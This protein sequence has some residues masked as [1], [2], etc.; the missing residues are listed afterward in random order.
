MRFS[1]PTPGAQPVTAWRPPLYPVPRA[2]SPF[3]HFYFTRPIAVDQKNWSSP[4][5]RY[6]GIFFKPGAVHT[7]I[8]I[9]AELGTPVLAAGPG[10]VVWASWGLYSSDPTNKNDPYGLAVV[11]QHDFGYNDQTLFTVYAH[12]DQ[13]NVVPGQWLQTGD[14]LGELGQTGFT[15]GPHLHFEVRLGA[16]TYFN[17]RNPELWLVQ[18]QGWGVLAAR[19]TDSY[20]YVLT[21]LDVT[22]LSEETKMEWTSR[23]YPALGVSGDEYYQ[24]NLVMSDLPS[25]YYTISFQYLQK[26]HEIKVQILDGQVTYF[27]FRGLNGFGSTPPPTEKIFFFFTPTP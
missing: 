23:T 20:G 15:T 26:T 27:A 22:L 17:T 21:D 11:I 24:E 6:G 12:L 18:P 4:D 8:D 16:D 14:Q 1:L 10:E 2:A 5:Y 3:D 25:G 13:V 7:G 9:P 19:I